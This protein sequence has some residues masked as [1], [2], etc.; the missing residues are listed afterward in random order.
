[1]HFLIFALFGLSFCKELVQTLVFGKQGADDHFCDFNLSPAEAVTHV[2]I[3]EVIN[4][5]KDHAVARFR[6]TPV[7]SPQ[8]NGYSRIEIPD[9]LAKKGIEY[10]FQF[11]LEDGGQAFSENWTY[12]SGKQEFVLSSA[13]KKT[14][15]NDKRVIA[16]GGV[17]AA[18]LGCLAFSSIYKR[19]RKSRNNSL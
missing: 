17:I 11:N 7:G 8:A 10:S 1:M 15:Y 18:V 5:E 12:D 16:A 9:N 4:G 13:V 6:L 3:F 14:I 2:T 19:L